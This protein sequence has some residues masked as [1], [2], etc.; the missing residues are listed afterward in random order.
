MTKPDSA[1]FKRLE[2]LELKG[3]DSAKKIRREILQEVSCPLGTRWIFAS[4]QY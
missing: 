1:E 2:E 3:Y 4:V